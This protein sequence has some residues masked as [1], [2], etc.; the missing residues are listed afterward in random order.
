MFRSLVKWGI[1]QTDH[2][3]GLIAQTLGAA[4]WPMMTRSARRY[5]TLMWTFCGAMLATASTTTLAWG[6]EWTRLALIGQ[7]G[8]L[9]SVLGAVLCAVLMRRR[10]RTSDEVDF[11]AGIAGYPLDDLDSWRR[12][13]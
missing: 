6:A 9:L 5:R 10:S 11:A 1:D 13:S 2:V 4:R 3:N 12:A 7:A 8:M